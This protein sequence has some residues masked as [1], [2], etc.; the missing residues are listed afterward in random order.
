MSV[1]QKVCVVRDDREKFPIL[2][3]AHVRYFTPD[4][5]PH[6][7]HIVP[8]VK[9][10]P[11]GD[12]LLDEA[13]AGCIVE[14]KG[15]IQELYSNLIGQD[16]MRAVSAFRR[17]STSCSRPI[18]L[19]DLSLGDFYRDIPG[20]PAPGHILSELLRTIRPLGIELLTVGPCKGSNIRT[21][22]G[23]FIA[24][25]LIEEYVHGRQ[26]LT[27]DAQS[28]VAGRAQPPGLAQGDCGHGHGGPD[29]T[30]SEPV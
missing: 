12:Y 10:L 21:Q 24:H 5:R 18:L 17:L 26:Q 20:L 30:V 11:E 15:S 7:I 3:P 27:A 14:R 2:F 29:R 1:P 16:R 6:L 13:P 9:R 19:L 23:S 4:R 25:L 28:R 8:K 22:L